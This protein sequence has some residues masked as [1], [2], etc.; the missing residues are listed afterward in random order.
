MI[1]RRISFKFWRIIGSGVDVVVWG[2]IWRW[3]QWSWRYRWCRWQIIRRGRHC[4]WVVSGLC[5]GLQIDQRWWSFA[6]ELPDGWRATRRDVR[7][8]KMVAGGVRA[9]IFILH[10]AALTLGI[11]G[12]LRVLVVIQLGCKQ[13]YEHGGGWG[14][15]TAV[16]VATSVR[17]SRRS[18]SWLIRTKILRLGGWRLC[19]RAPTFFIWITWSAVLS[20][21]RKKGWIKWLGWGQLR[22]GGWV[23]YLNSTWTPRKWY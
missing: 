20:R 5:R 4:S 10:W 13:L 11:H 21:H 7:W 9:G 6:P 14:G 3:R 19:M 23:E 16:F 2:Y 22:A 15:G 17:E 12:V 18:W 8:Q 1:W